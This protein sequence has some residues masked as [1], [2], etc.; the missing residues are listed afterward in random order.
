M[1]IERHCKICGDPFTAIKTTQV[2]CKRKCFKRDYYLR[3]KAKTDA[4]AMAPVY[5]KRTCAFCQ[6][7]QTIPYDPVKNAD[8]YN[9]WE[10]VNCGVTN[11]ILWKYQDMPRSYQT[12]SAILTSVHVRP[13]ALEQSE[14]TVQASFI[15]IVT[16]TPGEFVREPAITQRKFLFTKV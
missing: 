5:P 15:T 14:V 1:K 2:F 8:K 11:E 13:F 6:V 7:M 3:N 16:E 12:I 4:L 10:C 9:K